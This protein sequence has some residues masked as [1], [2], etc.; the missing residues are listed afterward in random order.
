[1][2][3]RQA[4]PPRLQPDST[5]AARNLPADRPWSRRKPWR[6]PLDRSGVRKVLW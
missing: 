1:M 5:A 4:G 2:F 3:V 6:R